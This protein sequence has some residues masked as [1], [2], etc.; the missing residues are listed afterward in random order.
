MIVQVI[1]F[2][3]VVQ[4]LNDK[5]QYLVQLQVN[6]INKLINWIYVQPKL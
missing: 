1:T 6:F 4:H 3:L 2:W 5:A